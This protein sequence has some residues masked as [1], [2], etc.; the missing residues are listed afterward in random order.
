MMRIIKYFFALIFVLS[1]NVLVYANAKS[2]TIK[3]K[4][5]NIAKQEGVA[6]VNVAIKGSSIGTVSNFKGEF[7]I[8]LVPEGKQFIV[9]SCVGYKPI[10]VEIN[11]KSIN[12]MLI[13]MTQDFI[14][15]NQVVVT[16]DRNKISRKDAPVVVNSI[17]AQLLENTS[18]NTMADG[19]MF[20][21]G[22]RVENDCSNCGF[23]QVRMN[24]L[25]GPYTQI[26]I[27][28]RPIFSGLAG[29]YGLEHIPPSMIQRIEVVRG[30]GS[31]LF[32]GNA[33]AGTINVITKDPVSNSF[34]VGTKYSSLGLGVKS[35]GN[36]SSDVIVDFN[37]SIVSEDRKSGV[38]LFGMKRNRGAW[39]ANNDGF[40]D[41]VKLNNIS[42]GFN[43]FHRFSDLTKLTAEFHTVNE[44]R[45]GGDNIDLPAHMSLI[46]EQVEHDINSGSLVLDK[47]FNADKESKLSIYAS[48]QHID[49]KSY[50][51]AA[52]LLNPEGKFLDTPIYD[53]SSYGATEDLA[54]STGVQ[55]FT[56]IDKLL[57]APADV[58]LGVENVYNTLVDD[59]LA[60]YDS[61]KKKYVPTTLIADQMSNTTGGFAQSKWD[62]GFATFLLG[63]RLDSY[64]IKNNEK[65]T[66]ISDIVIS[67]RANVLFK[68]NEDMQL[69][70]S[71]AKGFRAPQIFDEDLHI[72][73]SAARRVT[74]VVAD[75]LKPE[76][77]NSY[78]IS[79][80]VD[81][82]FGNMQTYFLIEGFYTDLNDSFHNDYGDNDENGNLISTRTNVKGAIV[83]G[84]NLE[85]KL[86]P[87]YKFD[88]Q[89][90]MTL[91]D[92]KYKED[93]DNGDLNELISDKMLRT[94]STYGYF[95]A[96]WKPLHE[97]TTSLTANYSGSMDLVHLGSKKN[98]LGLPEG[99]T[100][101]KS[102][103]F[104]DIGINF[105]Y[106][107][108]LG[109]EVKL[110]FD[111][112]MKNIFNS[113]QK[114]FDRG[115]FRDAGWVY[116]PLNPRTF[117]FG[118]KIGNLL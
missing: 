65:H 80:D 113:Y 105:A 90:G 57:F 107:F 99:D 49:R 68:L 43:A 93:V 5:V 60:Y 33:I 103:D 19:L 81:K 41:I 71:Y 6:F 35:S 91:Q 69:R 87:S 3:G 13:E 12:N 111:F 100:L 63:A 89:M 22:L 117:Y 108:D 34:K 78:T 110:E 96:N 17:G 84:V 75:N 114:D 97:F 25:E 92:S 88:F 118:I 51:G 14:G 36:A 32:G 59:K 10:V 47:Y 54:V 24:G 101:E 74:H 46:A 20:S 50:Y 66:S 40:S 30:G 38:F 109:E 42:A 56:K 116:G 31:A 9:A 73:A 18:A 77:S 11:P 82:T 26:L 29:V 7:T 85:F 61:K 72:E 37:G 53:I 115:A 48:A 55:F 15:L 1:A 45:R 106:H 62:L 76:S 23:S 27:N 28:S 112:G 64:N 8:S 83:N 58:I 44:F 4:I 2:I 94:P 104:M 21:P 70:L 67:P 16:A 95:A 79:Y 86:A 102:G 39:D 52:Q 98:E